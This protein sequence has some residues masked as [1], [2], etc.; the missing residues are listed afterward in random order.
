M[1]I[2]EKY[3]QIEMEASTVE[4]KELLIALLFGE[5][6]EFEEGPRWLKAFIREEDFNKNYIDILLSKYNVTYSVSIIN[7][8]NWNAEWEAGFQPVQVDDFCCV[9]A[10]FHPPAGGVQFD[11][12]I[13]PQMSF[14]TGHHA[15]TFLMLQAMRTLEW[16]DKN[17]A[18]F[19]TGTGVLAIL[20]EKLGASSVLA[21]DIDEW[22]I[23]NAAD[24]F[25][26]NDCRRVRLEM[27][28][29][30]PDQEFDIILANI[31]RNVIL[32]QL[33]SLRRQLAPDGK[34]LFSGLLE[35]DQPIVLEAAGQA[36]LKLEEEREKDSWIC[37]VMSVIPGPI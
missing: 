22:S 27:A 26:V 25:V 6:F 20:A 7:N 1:L 2:N 21:I 35:A 36:G 9:R 30:L 10:G 29:R 8:R 5:G 33:P 12:V 13:T 23:S 24:N 31:N 3:V 15:T 32:Q 17:V 11:V 19:G 16:K 37:L 4:E 28:D 18:D 14:G 34:V